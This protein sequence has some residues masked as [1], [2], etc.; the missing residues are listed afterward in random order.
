MGSPNELTEV[1]SNKTFGGYQKV[2][3]HNS[4]LLGCTMNFGVYL[5]PQAEEN[6]VPVIYWLSGLTCSEA[7]FIQ[8]AGAQRCALKQ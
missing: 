8:K 7:N 1:S 4:K 2:F 6:K 3:S 5:P